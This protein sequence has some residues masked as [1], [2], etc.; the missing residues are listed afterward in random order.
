MASYA[1]LV[2]ALLD[3]FSYPDADIAGVSWGGL[4]AQEFATRYPARTRR[5]ILIS[6]AVARGFGPGSSIDVSTELMWP[7]RYFDR[8]HRSRIMP[9]IL[10][11]E[12][13]TNAEL[14]VKFADLSRQPSM[15]G[16]YAQMIAA[17][18][19]SLA[20]RPNR[21]PGPLLVLSGSQD[22]LFPAPDPAA[23]QRL[24]PGARLE[25]FDSGHLL[26]HTRGREVSAIIR[27]FLEVVP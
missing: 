22:P 19:W 21:I 25:I 23:L 5:L 26:I 17:H 11:G 16:Y 4:L 10:G 9:R 13:L 6:T 2:R 27:E 8:Q 18:L 1:R 24:S 12:A 15:A 20:S 3:H 7:R 14:A